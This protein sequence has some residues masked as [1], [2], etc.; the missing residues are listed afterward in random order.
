M[1]L[2]SQNMQQL[3]VRCI[4]SNCKI[5]SLHAFHLS[6]KTPEKELRHPHVPLHRWQDIM[7]FLEFMYHR[8]IKDVPYSVRANRIS[9]LSVG[10]TSDTVARP[11]AA[12]GLFLRVKMGRS[13]ESVEAER[14]GVHDVGGLPDGDPLDLQE[15]PVAYWERQ[16]HA[17]VGVISAKGHLTVDE[18]RRGIES[19]PPS[20]YESVT[21]YEKWARS[22]A[23]I[24]MERGVIT[25]AELDVIMGKPDDTPVPVRF[26]RGDYVRVRSEKSAVR[27]RK[28]HLR[29]PGYV[30]GVVGIVDSECFGRAA[31][32]EQLAFRERPSLQPLYCVKFRQADLWEQYPGDREDTLT[33]EIYQ[34]W[35]EAAS[36]ED[37][38]QQASHAGDRARHLSGVK[39]GEKRKHSEHGAEGHH[40]HG[41]HADHVGAHDH[42]EE[43]DHV[44]EEREKVEQAAIDAEG[45]DSERRRLTEALLTVLAQKGIVTGDEVRT[46][47]EAMDAKGGMRYGARLVARAWRDPSF[48]QRLLADANKAAAELSIS[49]SNWAPKR[50]EGEEASEGP[51]TIAGTLLRVVENTDKVHNLIVCTLCSCYP[52]SVL[53]MSPP[54]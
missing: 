22:L 23:V 28:P 44:H 33:M 20:A 25:A 27:W 51:P 6:L 53:G 24:L 41:D 36:Q 21:Y 35:L 12:V 29:T 47:V 48:K 8:K 52:I 39:V 11:A 31:N 1:I 54:W 15:P 38:L 9:H 32:P 34:P 18:L 14:L 5:V 3:S 43:H 16:T 4:G 19:L 30:F 45:D 2:S 46:A 50:T 7:S 49:T 13:V 10:I 17:L 37:Y 40:H 26:S 42:G